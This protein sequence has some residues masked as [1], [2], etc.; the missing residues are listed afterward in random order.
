MITNA[1]EKMTAEIGREPA[2][3]AFHLNNGDCGLVI[4][5]DGTTEMFQQG[6]CIAGLQ[7]T[8][9]T[10]SAEDKQALLNGQTL[11]VLSIVAA[12]PELQSSILAVAINQGA[13]DIPTANANAA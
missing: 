12:S 11:M 9:S 2:A 4:R 6:F 3:R 8:H 7:Q 13:V 1:L 5:K 10:M